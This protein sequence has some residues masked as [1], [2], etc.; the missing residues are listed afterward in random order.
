MLHSDKQA[1]RLEL[2]AEAENAMTQLNLAVDAIEKA[3]AA[4]FPVSVRCW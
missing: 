1:D 4:D 2:R 3:D